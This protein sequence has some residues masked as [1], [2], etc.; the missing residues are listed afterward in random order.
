MW[1]LTGSIFN[2][3]WL[4]TMSSYSAAISTSRVVVSGFGLESRDICSENI[5]VPPP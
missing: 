1:L 2:G 5:L 3:A 4:I